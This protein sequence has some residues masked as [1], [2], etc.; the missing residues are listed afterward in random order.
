MVS[1]ILISKIL[2]SLHTCNLTASQKTLS[3]IVQAV[4]CGTLT[5]VPGPACSES[6]R[7][8]FFIEKL[9]FLP[10]SLVRTEGMAINML[11]PQ[12]PRGLSFVG[13]GQ[14]AMEAREL[15]VEW[16]KGRKVIQAPCR[17]GSGISLKAFCRPA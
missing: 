7:D 17:Y 4:A 16:T 12:H 3:T 9:F 1:S 13:W 5:V 15:T 11:R 6:R 2:I 10:C 14:S 8:F